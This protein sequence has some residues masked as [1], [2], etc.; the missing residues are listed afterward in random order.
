MKKTLLLFGLISFI[1]VANPYNAQEDIDVNNESSTEIETSSLDS[2]EIASSKEEIEETFENL[3]VSELK[4]KEKKTE[5]KDN[6]TVVQQIKM[7]R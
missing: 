1:F 5:K 6:S 4:A 7:K 2:L 3:D